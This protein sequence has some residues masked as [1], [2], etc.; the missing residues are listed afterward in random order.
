MSLDKRPASA[1]SATHATIPRACAPWLVLAA[2]L[3][4]PPLV[5][6]WLSPALAPQGWLLACLAQ[7]ATMVV[8]A[9][10][11]N[12]LLGETG[13]LS[14]GHAAPAGLGALAAAHLFNRYALPLPLL[15]LAGGVGGAAFGALTA[16]VAARRAGTAFAMITLGLGELVAA[17]AWA[18]PGWFGGEA[19]VAIDRASGPA[20][21]GWTF[22]P[23]REAYWVIAAWCLLASAAIFALSRTPFARLANAVRD[24][25]VRA[26]ALGATPARV[27]AIMI[28][29]SAAFAGVA[30]TLTLINVELAAAESVGMMRSAAVLIA[31]VTGGAASFF[32]PALGAFVWV[33]FSVGVASVSRGWM[34]Y[35]GLFFIV[36]VLGAPGGLAGCAARERARLARHGWRRCRAPWLAATV[37]AV[38][39]AAALVLA[40]QWAYAARFRD[41]DPGAWFAAPTA[42]TAWA[43]AA[44]I[45]ALGGFAWL[46]ARRAAVAARALDP[47]TPEGQT[48]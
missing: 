3:I 18:L 41:D 30:G 5:G 21:A 8:F 13:L 6:A 1:P 12:L 22:G 2:C 9:L 39:A 37:A 33:A 46:A 29:W 27:R 20:I 40:V 44:L 17:A 14:F 28:V 48:R 43:L 16:L 36:V 42:A 15:P 26:A 38:S 32:G 31:T 7:A 10:S 19:G 4:V 23:A 25:P 45:A 35:V 47:A 34:L 24:N 11:Y